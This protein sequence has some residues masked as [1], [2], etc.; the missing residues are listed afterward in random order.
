MESRENGSSQASYS[1]DDAQPG[2]TNNSDASSRQSTE[3]HS[4]DRSSSPEG[5]PPP[6]P[7]RPDTLSLL[8]D[9]GAAPGT[10][11]LNTPTPHSCLQARAT[12]AVSLTEIAPQDNS[13]EPSAAR[14]FPGT[15]HAKASLGHLATPRAGSDTA[16]SA[17]IGSYAPYSEA[18]DV[19]NIFSDLASSELGMVQQDSTGLMQFPEF[20]ADDVEDDFASEFEPV[21]DIS[22]GGENE[23]IIHPYDYARLPQLISQSARSGSREMEGEAE[24]LHYS[25]SRW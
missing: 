8:D 14:P 22:E 7:P 15:V 12:T 24:A 25:L 2:R 11:R 10:H 9:G 13:K 4:S 3:Q 1:N 18:G 17:S 16:D 21:G 6:L 19:E 5:R 23:G 20:Q